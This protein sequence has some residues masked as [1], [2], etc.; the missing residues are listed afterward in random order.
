MAEREDRL[1]APSR[2]LRRALA[3]ALVAALAALACGGPDGDGREEAP[4]EAE[5]A[6]ES[7]EAEEEE[8]QLEEVNEF[9]SF[10]APDSLVDLKLWAGHGGANGAWNFDGYHNGN[11]TIVV[12]LGWRVEVTYQTLDA[13]VPHSAAVVE[14]ADPVPPDGSNVQIAF[15]GASTPSLVSGITSTRDPV[16]FDFVADEAGRYWVFCGVPGHGRGG[17]WI[18]FEVSDTAG[19]P[20][21]RTEED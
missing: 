12:P 13:N 8:V 6:P 19:A 20:D 2:R 7:V 9:L 16:E 21:F 4:A 3:C 1:E 18:W 14:P 5:P 11:A 15:R 10:S 17:M